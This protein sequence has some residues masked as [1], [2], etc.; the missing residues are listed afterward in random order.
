MNNILISIHPKHVSNILN[1]IKKFE[2]RKKVAKK[3]INKIIIYSTFPE[4]M[5]VAEATIDK[6][7]ADSPSN[8]WK[9]TKHG[10]GINKKFFDD[11][12]K[13]SKLA[14]AYELKDVKIYK[15]PKKLEHFGI[16]FAP[17]SFIYKPLMIYKDNVSI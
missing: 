7:L 4:K 11:Y 12:F 10:A 9:K 8:L 2:Y 15:K 5:I 17:Q 16:S 13:S 6:I 1:G 3:D 14:Y